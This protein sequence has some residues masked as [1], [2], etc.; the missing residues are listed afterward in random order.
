MRYLEDYNMEFPKLED[1]RPRLLVALILS[2]KKNTH[3]KKKERLSLEKK[4][5]ETK[6]EKTK[7]KRDN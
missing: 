1:A 4:N 3:T 6:L 2:Y 7:M 5:R